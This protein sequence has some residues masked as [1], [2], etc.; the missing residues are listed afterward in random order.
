[1]EPFQAFEAAR[2]IPSAPNGSGTAP[3]QT[4]NEFVDEQ[5]ER[6]EERRSVW[7]GTSCPW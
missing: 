1:M 5:V 4:S 7:E 6:T 3:P 2:D